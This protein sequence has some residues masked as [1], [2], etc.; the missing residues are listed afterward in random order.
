MKQKRFLKILRTVLSVLI[1]V[2][3]FLQLIG[4]WRNAVFVFEPMLGVVL[5]LQAVQ[6]WKRNR[7]LG[8]VSLCASALLFSVAGLV[9]FL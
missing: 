2:F 7:S 1:A 3:A 9:L 4:V 5:L 6:E 8:I